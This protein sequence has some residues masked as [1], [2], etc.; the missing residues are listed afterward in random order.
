MRRRTTIAELS[1]TES[2][3][4]KAEDSGIMDPVGEMEEGSEES[5]YGVE[6]E[7]GLGGLGLEGIMGSVDSD[8]GGFETEVGVVGNRGVI[9]GDNAGESYGSI[10]GSAA[11]VESLNVVVLCEAEP[12]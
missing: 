2:F 1:I 11:I 6:R 8:E 3:M 9:S 7:S 10:L 12:V 4:A 5:G